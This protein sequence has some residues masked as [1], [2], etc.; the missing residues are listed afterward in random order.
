MLTIN[1][2]IVP[3][4]W[5]T[6]KHS[7]GRISTDRNTCR[8]A[9]R[10]E[11]AHLSLGIQNLDHDPWIAIGVH[12]RQNELRGPVRSCSKQ[13]PL[14]LQHGNAGLCLNCTIHTLFNCIRRQGQEEQ[15]KDSQGDCQEYAVPEDQSQAKRTR[16]SL[17]VCY[18]FQYTHLHSRLARIVLLCTLLLIAVQAGTSLRHLQPASFS[19]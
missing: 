13:F 18:C 1:R 16:S 11:V 3:G 10:R 19:L 14:Y 8:A 4:G 6:G 17:L 15:R 12:G 5:A 2:G 7:T 9:T